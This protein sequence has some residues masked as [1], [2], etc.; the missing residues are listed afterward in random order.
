MEVDSG[1]L[2]G[3]AVV[4]V[5]S[6]PEDLALPVAFAGTW[7]VIVEPMEVITYGDAPSPTPGLKLSLEVW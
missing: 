5:E 1:L 2:A 3:I 7:I 6:W 4:V